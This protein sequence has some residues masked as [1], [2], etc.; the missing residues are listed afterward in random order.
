MMYKL[1]LLLCLISALC[2]SN[3]AALAD[4]QDS[5]YQAVTVVTGQGAKNRQAGFKRC[6]DKVLVRVSGDQRLLKLPEMPEL[7]A[8]A[9]D[10][11][12]SY[13]YRDRLEGVPIHDE[14][15]TY[16]RPHNLTCRYQPEIIDRLLMQLGSRPWLS[17]RPKL[18]VFLDVQRGTQA[19]DVVADNDRDK[20]M[21]EAFDAAATPL[22]LMVDFPTHAQAAELLAKSKRDRIGELEPKDVPSSNSVAVIGRL[23]WSDKDLG[24]VATW[25]IQSHGKPVQW[26]V[27]GVNFDEAFR[28]AVKGVAQI[29][30]G[31]GTPDPSVRGEN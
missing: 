24:W 28:V 8:R 10:F 3:S 13:S 21:R 6:L 2:T 12:R 23:V 31:N 30:S 27:R 11:V 9:G 19:Y 5:L 4:S 26:T 16:D 7:R 29:L 20:A 22:A 25:R 15:G 18:M 14:Q 17:A 1:P